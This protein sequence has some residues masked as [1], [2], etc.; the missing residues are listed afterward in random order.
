MRAFDGWQQAVVRATVRRRR[1][2]KDAQRA[3]LDRSRRIQGV[4]TSRQAREQ[5]KASARGTDIEEEGEEAR[6]EEVSGPPVEEKEVASVAAEV[7]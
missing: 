5:A 4:E 7:D 3:R 1:L 2:Q 6:V